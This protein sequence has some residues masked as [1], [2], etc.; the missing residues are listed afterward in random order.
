MEHKFIVL[1]IICFKMFTMV[2]FKF[3]RISFLV[4]EFNMELFKEIFFFK[5][6]F[7]KI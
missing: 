7:V 3:K 4:R 5:F 2:W 1:L 6:F